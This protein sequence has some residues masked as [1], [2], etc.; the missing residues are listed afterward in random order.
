MKIFEEIERLLEEAE[1]LAHAKRSPELIALVLDAA[2]ALQ[3]DRQR[4]EGGSENLADPTSFRSLNS[5]DESSQGGIG[6]IM[7]RTRI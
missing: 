7:R 4:Y 2:W 5:P 3:R 1:G 6:H